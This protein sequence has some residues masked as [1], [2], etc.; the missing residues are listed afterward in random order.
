MKCEVC[1][2][3]YASNY[4][5]QHPRCGKCQSTRE[6]VAKGGTNSRTPRSKGAEKE[7]KKKLRRRARALHTRSQRDSLTAQQCQ[8]VAMQCQAIL[9]DTC[10]TNSSP[11]VSG[12]VVQHGQQLFCGA[13]GFADDFGGVVP[14]T[15]NHVFHCAS[16]AKVFV[17]TAMQQLVERGLV[18]LNDRVVHHL[19]YF[20]LL[21][22][23]QW[24]QFGNDKSASHTIT[25]HQMLTHTAGMPDVADEEYGWGNPDEG[26][27]VLETY[28]RSLSTKQMIGPP[29]HI[30]M[31]SN[32]AFNALADVVA[33]VS[34]MTFESYMKE[35]IF[36]PLGMLN[37]TFFYPEVSEEIRT[38]G[39]AGEP[40]VRTTVGYPYNRVHAG[41][42]TLNTS[43]QDMS[44]FMMCLLQGGE[45]N[46]HRIL[47]PES[48]E[49][50]WNEKETG[51]FFRS[52]QVCRIG[53]SWFLDNHREHAIVEHEGEDDGF[54]AYIVLMPSTSTGVFLASNWED[55]EVE[56][57]AYKMLDGVLDAMGVVPAMPAGTKG[58]ADGDADSGSSS[59]SD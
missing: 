10:G 41:S 28:V 58:A 8:H 51:R 49:T 48:I 35:N 12:A 22:P 39:H 2:I 36:V 46:G 7:K 52:P 38:I 53:L 25:L 50:M 34:G 11:G 30:T 4:R 9:E 26:D 19:P 18:R 6:G 56:E 14:L 33:K 40:A 17:A 15:S 54:T 43:A 20:A 44:A 24:E 37:S 32:M 59:G 27:E 45:L 55:L 13:A 23:V 57:V 21:D 42:S 5:G 3:K 47:T 16:L 31:Y 1:E 29:S